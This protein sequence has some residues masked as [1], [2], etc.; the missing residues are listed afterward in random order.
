M[1]QKFQIS[2]GQ[3]TR[4]VGHERQ[5]VRDQ[6]TNTQCGKYIYGS[7][8]SQECQP[9]ATQIETVEARGP[10]YDRGAVMD[11]KPATIPIPKVERTKARSDDIRVIYMYY[12]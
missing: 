11:R 2:H 8:G 7:C 4:A 9:G 5:F 12:L 3:R 6:F 1:Y 10:A